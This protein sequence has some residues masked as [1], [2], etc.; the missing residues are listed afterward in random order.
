MN[1]DWVLYPVLAI[2]V[3]VAG[4]ILYNYF[5]NLRPGREKKIAM[6]ITP[7]EELILSLICHVSA[8]VGL[9]SLQRELRGIKDAEKQLS[10]ILARLRERG[11]IVQSDKKHYR[12]T[13][14]GRRIAAL[15][16]KAK[17]KRRN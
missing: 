17:S 7:H 9:T 6:A 3:F 10:I 14:R 15:L 2:V 12:A 8:A 16:A 1:W 11:C 13:G 5:Q 4:F